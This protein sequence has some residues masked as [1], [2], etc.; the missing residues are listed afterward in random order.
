M[1]SL[2]VSRW[3]IVTDSS[4]GAVYVSANWNAPPGVAS[5]Q[6][7]RVDMS[8]P[9]WLVPAPW[10]VTVCRVVPVGLTG[11][12]ASRPTPAAEYS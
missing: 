3:I 10:M 4:P 1:V 8:S 12:D 2:L 6:V 11:P 7:G 5:D 9:S